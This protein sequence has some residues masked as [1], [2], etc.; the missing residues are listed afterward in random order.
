[1][2]INGYLIIMQDSKEAQ[3]IIRTLR[4]ISLNI[5]ISYLIC[6]ITNTAKSNQSSKTDYNIKLT[7]Y[8]HIR[9]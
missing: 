6:F 1:M 8:R 2:M 4:T 5:K 7:N 3:K 9:S